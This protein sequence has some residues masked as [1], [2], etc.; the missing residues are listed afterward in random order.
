MPR[1]GENI[2]KRK[3]NRWEGRYSIGKNPLTGKTQYK[4]VY[5]KT[6]KITKDKLIQAI[7]EQ[8][9]IESPKMYTPFSIIATEWLENKRIT[10]K[11]STYARYSSIVTN[12]ILPYF[13]NT[14]LSD[15]NAETINHFLLL[16]A[17]SG[18]LK[19]QGKLSIKTV[20]DIFSVLKMILQFANV[21]N[22][23]WAAK[24]VFLP[25][26]D[27]NKAHVRTLSIQEQKKLET[28]LIKNLDRK[29]LAILMSLY[30]GLRVG[31]ICALQ[32]DNIDI[33]YGIISVQKTLQ[34]IQHISQGSKTKVIIDSPKSLCSVRQIPI[35][36]FL[37]Q[38]LA[39]QSQKSSSYFLTNDTSRFIEPRTLQRKL[40]KI[41]KKLNIKNMSFHTLRHTFATRCIEN[42]MNA[43]MLSELL[44]HC[45]VKITLD[46]YVHP[47]MIK[48]QAY[49]N[50]LKL[51]V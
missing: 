42:N 6:Y 50:K 22:S 24:N 45:S 28:Y 12:H 4:S 48:K 51:I 32:W 27:G 18:N 8:S 15:I 23:I 34:R 44:G 13:K 21:E 26:D 43:K 30:T 37:R 16:K 1:R 35:P 5:G 19:K 14:I 9:K 7:T 25:R 36:E 33:H 31:E 49:M 38:I 11:M 29:N 3:D 39:K 2:F 47:T 41:S 46:R 20:K 10:I 40:E 17:K